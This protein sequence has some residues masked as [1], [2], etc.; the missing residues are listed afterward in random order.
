MTGDAESSGD[1]AEGL[2][3]SELVPDGSDG[4][5][6]KAALTAVL[7]LAVYFALRFYWSLVSFLNVYLSREYADLFEAFVNLALLLLL[8]AAFVWL[9]R[10]RD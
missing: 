6:F 1:R 7:V 3:L 10:N 9:M 2:D 8:A 5:A 4:F